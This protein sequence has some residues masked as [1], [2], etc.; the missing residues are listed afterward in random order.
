MDQQEFNELLEEFR[1]ATVGMKESMLGTT[2]D[3][4]EINSALR[5]SKGDIQNNFRVISNNLALISSAET[6]ASA[7]INGFNKSLNDIKTLFEAFTSSLNPKKLDDLF[8]ALLTS[9][10]IFKTKIQGLNDS[11]STINTASFTKSLSEASKAIDQFSDLFKEFKIPEVDTSNLTLSINDIKKGIDDF[12]IKMSSLSLPEIQKIDTVNL[13]S[14]IK[15]VESELESFR[16]KLSSLSLPE[17]DETVISSLSKFKDNLDSIKDVKLPPIT[18]LSS[19]TEPLSNKTLTDTTS[20]STL[21]KKVDTN[22]SLIEKE[23]KQKKTETLPLQKQLDVQLKNIVKFFKEFNKELN[24]FSSGSKEVKSAPPL[25][26][27]SAEPSY[28]KNLKG[29]AEIIRKQGKQGDT[30]LAHINPEEAKLLKERGGS[31]EINPVTGIPQFAPEDEEVEIIKDTGDVIKVLRKNLGLLNSQLLTTNTELKE[32][33]G[34]TTR[35]DPSGNLITL[36]SYRLSEVIPGGGDL[37][38]AKTILA[39]FDATRTSEIDKLIDS[40]DYSV[41]N[42]KR[43]FGLVEGTLRGTTGFFNELHLRIQS[44]S[45]TEKDFYKLK[46]QEIQSI[47]STL[48]TIADHESAMKSYGNVFDVLNEKWV[49]AKEYELSLLDNTSKAELARQQMSNL[50]AETVAKALKNLNEELGRAGMVLKP[51]TSDQWANAKELELSAMTA[52]E[53]AEYDRIEGIKRT[54]LAEAQRNK[55]FEDAIG[56]LGFE[57]DHTT[58]ATERYRRTTVDL[59]TAQLDELSILKNRKKFEDAVSS[60]GFE[61]DHT[62]GAVEKYR[63]ASVD[64]TTAQFEELDVLKNRKKFEET[65]TSLGFEIDNTAGAVEKY[66]RATVDLTDDQLREI[67]GLKNKKKFED[68]VKSLGFEIDHTTGAVKKFRDTTTKLTSEQREELESLRQRRESEKMIEDI[69]AKITLASANKLKIFSEVLSST[70]KI[71]GSTLLN[72]SK[73]QSKY[74]ELAESAGKGLSSLGDIAM[75]IGGPWGKLIGIGLKLGSV[76]ASLV[77]S[78]FKHNEA[79]NTAYENLSKFGLVDYTGIEGL[80]SNLQK[81][82]F[83][84]DELGKF[85]GILEAVSPQLA[86][87]GTTAAD[88]ARKVATTFK[89]IVNS[90]AETSLRMLGYNSESL[91]KTFIDYQVMQGRLGSAQGKSTKQLAEES[92]KYAETLDQLTKLTGQSR[93]ELKKRQDAALADLKLRFAMEDM[94]DVVKKRVIDAS[95]MIADFGDENAAGFR[96]LL[97]NNG[98][99]VDEASAR[100]ALATGGAGETIAKNVLSGNITTAEAARQIASAMKSTIDNIKYAGRL[101]EDVGKSFSIGVAAM[102]GA[103]K[104][105]LRTAEDDKIIAERQKRQQQAANDVQRSAEERRQRSERAFQQ[106]LDSLNQQIGKKVSSAFEKLIDIV[107]KV[108]YAF[109]KIWNKFSGPLGLEKVDETVFLSAEDLEKKRKETESKIAEKEQDIAKYEQDPKI[110]KYN[111]AVVGTAKARAEDEANQA[112]LKEFTEK[113]QQKGTENTTQKEREILEELYNRSIESGDKLQQLAFQLRRT[114]I[115]LPKEYT[116]ALNERDALIKE[117]DKL[118]A[119]IAKSGE[120]SEEGRL[121]EEKVKL[122]MDLTDLEDATHLKYRQAIDIAFKE[123]GVT[124]EILD[125]AAAGEGKLTKE[126]GKK[127]DKYHSILD[128]NK[129]ELEENNNAIKELRSKINTL[130]EKIGEEVAT[131]TG[132]KYQPS[133]PSEAIG[134]GVGATENAVKAMEFF[135]KQGWTK[136]QAAGIVGNLQQESGKNLSTSA[137]NKKEDARGIAQW[138]KERIDTFKKKYGKDILSATLQEQLEFIDWELK[139]TEKE[140]GDAL[141]TARTAQEAA[142]IFDT[143]FERSAGTK[144]TRRASNAVTL[145][146]QTAAPAKIPASMDTLK[147]AGLKIKEG[148]V[149]SPGSMLDPRIISLSQQIQSKIPGFYIFTGFNDNFHKEKAPGAHTRGTAVDFTL[150]K[151]PTVEEGKEIVKTLKEM[152]FKVA[153]DEYNNPSKNSTG[154]HIHAQLDE[155]GGAPSAGTTQVASVAPAKELGPTATTPAKATSTGP[156]TSNAAVA[157]FVEELY[158]KELGTPIRPVKPVESKQ[159]TAPQVTAPTTATETTPTAQ[160]TTVNIPMAKTTPAPTESTEKKITQGD[161]SGLVAVAE[162]LDRLITVVASLQENNRPDPAPKLGLDISNKLTEVINLLEQTH[163]LQDKV[164]KASPIA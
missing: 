143:K 85:S 75:K 1:A 67:E 45:D 103:N 30:I 139:T 7:V 109:A 53:K 31:G 121:R 93:D 115:A 110:K 28:V 159:P 84:V 57:I 34:G 17:I 47:K 144:V 35:T 117:R 164:Y 122:E 148:D 141:K 56:S 44:L 40:L 120:G 36:P 51:M 130:T 22:L 11:I 38:S 88:G 83:T 142:A 32:I 127:F 162:K 68:E 135:V 78:A 124:Q 138:R 3:I 99:I 71:I 123:S 6:K 163:R 26:S 89:E 161:V 146:N 132:V 134:P 86:A 106:T 128:K 97:A 112:A 79:I 21:S 95:M 91:F 157:S 119:S 19:R 37:A 152:G 114:K 101:S 160:P 153:I 50:G 46:L 131:R 27:K 15:N 136:E 108:G 113:L 104:Y 64:L 90:E 18:E 73:G 116:N 96:T 154:G 149:Q 61:I 72:S 102:D 52:A 43:Q 39:S 9:S 98:A 150:S 23:T 118:R 58:G 76:L 69:K 16:T 12:K 87:L 54:T 65:I 14:T 10:T 2:N 77:G 33:A 156:T 62:A 66:R 80:F 92:V 137:H 100:F 126:E 70:S 29:M 25:T 42:L 129:K 48:K 111:E 155:A 8:N 55:K 13:T 105:A 20:N 4:E 74:G 81:A 147:Q 125:K 145:L 151:P 5:S 82:G 107:N 49:S 60:L 94:N 24:S 59:T 158:K 41:S 63:K 140:A 133:T